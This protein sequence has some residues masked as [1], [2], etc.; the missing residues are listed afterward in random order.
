MQGKKIGATSKTVYVKTKNG[1][2]SV[3]LSISIGS[4][5]KISV[6]PPS[7]ITTISNEAD[8]SKLGA[9]GTS[10][11]GGG[12]TVD[13]SITGS[14]LKVTPKEGSAGTV[15]ELD[16]G[17]Q[18]VYAAVTA[19]G[20]VKIYGNFDGSIFGSAKTCDLLT[21]ASCAVK[22]DVTPQSSATGIVTVARE[23]TNNGSLKLTAVKPGMTTVTAS[24]TE[25]GKTV[26]YKYFVTVNNDGSISTEQVS[27]FVH[28]VWEFDI[29]Q[30]GANAGITVTCDSD[31]PAYSSGGNNYVSASYSNNKFKI[32]ALKPT[33]D[34]VTVTFVMN[35]PNTAS[36]IVNIS[37]VTNS[38][39]FY[40]LS[41]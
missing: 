19:N 10:V 14:T 6:T 21:D 23:A 9:S 36:E 31:A 20:G 30:A 34:K 32:E 25:N 26:D 24:T 28:N 16:I 38:L 39:N 29:V 18:K 3:N 8:L 17:G 5:G 15:T 2:V 11:S 12:S 37:S 40:N 1:F 35:Y 4:D 27:R 13:A 41:S 7:V 33:T 22:S